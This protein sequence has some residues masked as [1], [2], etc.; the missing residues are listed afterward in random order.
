[1]EGILALFLAQQEATAG[2]KQG[3]DM[4]S[5]RRGLQWPWGE[6][7]DGQQEWQQGEGLRG[8]CRHPG[9]VQRESWALLW[10]SVIH[11]TWSPCGMAQSMPDPAGVC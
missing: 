2:F 8:S 5:I 7:R 10:V 9:V 11:L 4:A 6:G 1:M 3:A